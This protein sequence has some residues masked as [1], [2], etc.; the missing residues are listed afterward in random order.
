DDSFNEEIATYD[1]GARNYDPALGRWMNIDPLAEQMRRHSP[2]NYVFD[3]PVFFVDPDGMMPCPTGDC[4]E[5]EPL[6]GN[7]GQHVDYRPIPVGDGTA[8]NT[9]NNNTDKIEE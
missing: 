7:N 8:S 4:P 6:S 3:N 2:Y 1:F 5:E 9:T